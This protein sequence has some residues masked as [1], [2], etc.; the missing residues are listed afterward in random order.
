M[1]ATA[2]REGKATMVMAGI[3]M[4]AEVVETVTAGAVAAVEIAEAAVVVETAEAEGINMR[5]INN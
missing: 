3:V 4:T 2:G 1:L 5:D